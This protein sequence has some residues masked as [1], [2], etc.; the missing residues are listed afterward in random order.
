MGGAAKSLEGRPRALHL[1]LRQGCRLAAFQTSL[2]KESLPSTRS[3]NATCAEGSLS[4]RIFVPMNK[5]VRITLLTLGWL[6]VSPI[7]LARLII[8]RQ[9]KSERKRIETA[10]FIAIVKEQDREERREN[11]RLGIDDDYEDEENED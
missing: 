5:Y 6:F 1:L 2:L 8:L 11:R 7:M 3:N 4:C 9:R 10:K